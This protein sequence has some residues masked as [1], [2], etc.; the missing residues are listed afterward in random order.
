MFTEDEPVTNKNLVAG[1]LFLLF[2]IENTNM[3]PKPI[4]KQLGKKLRLIREYKELSLDQM[5]D[6]VGKEGSSRRA[7]VYEWENGIR[8]P[9]LGV[10]L[11]Y[12]QIVG[13]S[14]DLLIDDTLELNLGGG[15]H[16]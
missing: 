12:A 2:S 6:A 9:E 8:Q 15:V 16:E 4:P 11:A 13:I 5:A 3:S 1:F 10:L 14:T 7:R